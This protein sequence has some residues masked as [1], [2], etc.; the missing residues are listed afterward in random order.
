MPRELPLAISSDLGQ[1]GGR[2]RAAM[3][4]L[5][6]SVALL[7]LAAAPR[8]DGRGDEEPMLLARRRRRL[9]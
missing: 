9:D 7:W 3:G 6:E 4:K 8:P 5:I 2:R 1:R